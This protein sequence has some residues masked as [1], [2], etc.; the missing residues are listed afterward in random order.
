MPARTKNPGK[1]TLLPGMA[2]L[3]CGLHFEMR[4]RKY[5]HILSFVYEDGI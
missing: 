3:S 4:S 2:R 5:I 1:N